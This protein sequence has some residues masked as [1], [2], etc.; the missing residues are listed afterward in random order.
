[1]K[2]KGVGVLLV[3]V[4]LGLGA[5]VLRDGVP[6]GAAQQGQPAAQ[7][8]PALNEPG[9]RLQNEQNTIDVVSRFE[10]GLVFISTE[11][12]VPQDPFAMMFGG[13]QEEVQRG[14]GSGFFVNDAGDILTN[15]HVVAGEGGSGPQPK[16]T[17]RLMGQE[18]S[19]PA[20]VVGLAPQYDLAL[21]RAPGLKRELIRPIPLGDSASL[22]VGQ[23]AI[24]M[25]A[26]FGLDFSV[27]EGIVSSTARQI[28]I[29]FGGTGGQGITQKAIQT[30][31]AINPG[32]SGGPLL[33]S[34]GRVIGINT[35]IYS[36]AG[37]S[38]GVGQSAGVGFA[39]PIDT[40]KNLLPRLQAAQGGTVNAPDIGIRGGLAVQTRQGPLPVGLSVLSSA[41]KRQLGLPDQGLVVGQVLPGTPA[42]RAGVR[43]G[44][45]RQ[46][47]RG[48]LILLG[49][50]VITRA[51]GE[52]V[53]ALEDLQAALIDKKEGDTVTLTVVRGEATREVRLTLDASSFTVRTGQ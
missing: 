17:V 26:P 14:V 15:Y 51:D 40:A 37:Q 36:P 21:I 30:D 53:D 28:P 47:F 1:M 19:V 7:P 9:A 44:T 24:A 23:K 2:G 48:G 5:T 35:Q 22:K 13:G 43:A 16:I 20:Q 11:E 34:G 6:I 12:V 25:G 41:G 27:T 45:E 49:G 10:P 18:A 46:Q 3:L 38:S 42:A 31:A 52:P 33:D 8:T 29:G 32:N 39:I 4:G 50:D